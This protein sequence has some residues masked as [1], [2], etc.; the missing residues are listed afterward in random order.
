VIFG[1][2]LAVARRIGDD[3]GV[4]TTEP[5]PVKTVNSAALRLARTPGDMA[6]AVLVILVPVAILV[7][8]YVYFFGGNNVIAV[9]PSDAYAAARASSRFAVSEPASLPS[10]WRPI[11]AQFDPGTQATLRVGYIAPDGNGVQLIE[12]NRPAAKFISSELGNVGSIA[13]GVAIGTRNWGVVHA[14]KTSNLALVDAE[15]GRT[16]IVTGQASQSDLQ[17]LASALP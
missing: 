7:A 2:G 12:T 5:G 11:S 10:G 13:K 6:K 9:D 14:T 8:L 1:A 17:R 15:T 16:M 4:T 3:R